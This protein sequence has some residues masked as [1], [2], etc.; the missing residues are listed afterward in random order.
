MKEFSWFPHA[1]DFF[2][3]INKPPLP[4]KT[5]PTQKLYEAQRNKTEQLYYCRSKEICIW[6][7]LKV[8]EFFPS[9]I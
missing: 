2:K 6:C 7:S 1:V 3:N 9:S 8:L 4:R 5:T